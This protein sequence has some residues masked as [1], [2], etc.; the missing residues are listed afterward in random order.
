MIRT[1]LRRQEQQEEEKSRPFNFCSF[2]IAFFGAD[3]P[4]EDDEDEGVNERLEKRIQPGQVRDWYRVEFRFSDKETSRER[5]PRIPGGIVRV[6][7]FSS[8]SRRQHLAEI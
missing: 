8:Q 2:V 6:E 3:R 7:S 4:H 1:G 5:S